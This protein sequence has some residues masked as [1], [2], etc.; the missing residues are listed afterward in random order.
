[1]SR[2]PALDVGGCPLTRHRPQVRRV[3]HTHFPVCT[4]AAFC[5]SLHAQARSDL[6]VPTSCSF[7]VALLALAIPIHI[8]RRGTR[9]RWA[10]AITAYTRSILTAGAL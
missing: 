7:L 8:A 4:R 2:E 6:A 1:M 9:P 10:L 5:F 3:S